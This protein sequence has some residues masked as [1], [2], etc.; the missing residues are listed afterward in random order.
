MKI[1]IRKIKRAW[2]YCNNDTTHGKTQF[3]LTITDNENYNR[4]TIWLCQNCI[5]DFRTQ[6]DNEITRLYNEIK[7]EGKI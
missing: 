1:K 5:V 3:E 6:F 2:A 4:F 7:D